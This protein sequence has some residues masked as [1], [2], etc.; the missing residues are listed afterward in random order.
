MARIK[1]DY[2]SLSGPQIAAIMMLSLR[3]DQAGK[4]LGTM[5]DEELVY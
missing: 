1:V 3:D 5:D 4:L 2:R